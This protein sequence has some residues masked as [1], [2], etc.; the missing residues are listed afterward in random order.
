MGI[1]AIDI[2]TEPAL[3]F[4]IDFDDFWLQAPVNASEHPSGSIWPSHH[5]AKRA[6]DEPGLPLAEKIME[7][8]NLHD[9]QDQQQK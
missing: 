4:E 6:F 2:K 3:R 1:P 8:L 5:P 9:L 7:I